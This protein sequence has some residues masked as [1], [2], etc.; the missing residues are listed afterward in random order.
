MT[1]ANQ[2]ALAVI[3]LMATVALGMMAMLALG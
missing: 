1:P 3:I 2:A